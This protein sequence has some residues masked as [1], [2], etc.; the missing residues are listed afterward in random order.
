[1]LKKFNC[2]KFNANN[3]IKSRHEVVEELPLSIFING[4]YFVTAMISPQMVRE[5]VIGYLFSEKV[6]KNIEEIES[7]QIE[8]NIAKVIISI[9][10]KV[11]SVKKLIVSGCGGESSFLDELKLPKISSNLKIDAGDIFG[12]LKSLLNSDL[13]RVTGGVHIVGLFRKKAVICIS[14]DIGR[15]NA[16]DKVIGYGL[17]KNVD[18]KMTFVVCTG[19]ISFDMA[20]KCSVASIPI[21]A[22]RGATTSLA[23]EIAEKTGLTTIGFVRGRRMNIYTNRERICRIDTRDR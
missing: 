10:L 2:L 17:I 8:K 12:G 22:S 9:P 4:R 13:H 7:L 23:I 1:M 6:I 15:H 19:R 21:I 3:F 16:L 14:E 5:F 20:L 11:L 18:F